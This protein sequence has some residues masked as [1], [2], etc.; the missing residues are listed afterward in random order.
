MRFPLAAALVLLLGAGCAC[1]GGQADG[2]SGGAGGDG[3]SAGGSGGSAGGNATGGGAGGGG[4]GT[5]GRSGGG[6][7]GGSG[8][9]TG[10][11]G[12]GGGRA[13]YVGDGGRLELADFCEAAVEGFKEQSFRETVRCSIPIARA[14]AL[15]LEART[16]RPGTQ[17]GTMPFAEVWAN[18]RAP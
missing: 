9:G 15:H 7:G 10:G 13:V 8:G 11:L 2:G 4:G 14:E 18:A 1:G 16:H 12:G 5:G 6:T 17:N 3:G